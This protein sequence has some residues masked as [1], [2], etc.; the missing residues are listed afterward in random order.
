MEKNS[1]L[2]SIRKAMCWAS[3]AYVVNE[4]FLRRFA[5]YTP[6]DMTIEGEQLLK[7][8]G[9]YDDKLIHDM[10]PILNIDGWLILLTRCGKL[11][12]Y[13]IYPH[14]LSQ[15]SR[16]MTDCYSFTLEPVIAASGNAWYAFIIVVFIFLF[17]MIFVIS[18]IVTYLKQR[19]L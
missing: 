15:S 11:K 14:I 5:H 1:K 16:D 7:K 17:C 8:C 2:Y 12:S 13:S 10:V 4:K 9:K 19:K 6:E 18:V 3:H